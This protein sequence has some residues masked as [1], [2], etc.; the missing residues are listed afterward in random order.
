MFEV[1]MDGWSTEPDTHTHKNFN[2]MQIFQR[3][4]FIKEN[5]DEDYSTIEW[6][7]EL[8]DAD[9]GKTHLFYLI[10]QNSY[11]IKLNRIRKDKSFKLKNL[12]LKYVQKRDSEIEKNM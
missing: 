12:P 6:P 10:M 1:M 3:L 2:H 7:D 5:L 8:M 9:Q 11:L 4:I